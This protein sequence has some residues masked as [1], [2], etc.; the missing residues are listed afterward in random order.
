MLYMLGAVFPLSVVGGT[1]LN[2]TT[3]CWNGMGA[4]KNHQWGEGPYQVEAGIKYYHYDY[5][6]RH[7]TCVGCITRCMKFG[8]VKTGKYKGTIYEGPDYEAVS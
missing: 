8:I 2:T 3:N 6:V 1:L 7:R 4:T 5:V